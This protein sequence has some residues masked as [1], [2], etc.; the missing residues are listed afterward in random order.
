MD[1]GAA[2]VVRAAVA[3]I[4]ETLRSVPTPTPIGSG[5]SNNQIHF[6]LS[7]LSTLATTLILG[8]VSGFIAGVGVACLIWVGTQLQRQQAKDQVQDA[9]INAAYQIAP[10]IRD[11]QKEKK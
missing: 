4:V 8:A 6:Q 9:Y 3:D 2:K 1:E 7:G 5:N 10:Q 11:S